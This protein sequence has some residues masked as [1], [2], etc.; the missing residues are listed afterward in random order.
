M[1]KIATLNGEKIAYSDV[2]QGQPIVCVHGWSM[3]KGMF[4][5]LAEALSGKYRV[6][7]IDLAGHGN[8]KNAQGPFTIERAA[9]DLFL[10]CKNLGLQDIIGLGWSMGMHVWWEMIQ[11]HGEKNLSGLISQDMSPKVYNT[12]DWQ[13]GTLN[14]RTIDGIEDMLD[15]MCKDWTT[16][17]YRFVPRIFAQDLGDKW[18]ALA[19]RL[20]R[21]TLR[22]DP[23]IMACYWRSMSS[24]DYRSLLPEIKTP[25]LIAHGGLSQLY[26]SGV[27]EF[28]HKELPHSQIVELAESGH[29]PH[30]EQPELFTEML[31]SFTTKI[32]T[33]VKSSP[34]GQPIIKGEHHVH[35]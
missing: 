26:G 3:H 1:Q 10:L 9:N 25:T 4:S 5:D 30:L 31:I 17:T 24:K 35:I 14:G 28:L 22:N 29:A 32:Q 8:S 33:L 16:F 23:K 13:N 6:I 12:K 34:Q 2:G 21:D 15:D 20:M 7:C 11:Q 19:E 18:A 27:A